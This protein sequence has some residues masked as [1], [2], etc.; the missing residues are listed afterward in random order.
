LS[1]GGGGGFSIK[2]LIVPILNNLNVDTKRKYEPSD[3]LREQNLHG[4]NSA[5]SHFLV[6]SQTPEWTD[7]LERSPILE[8]N[9]HKKTKNKREESPETHGR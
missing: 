4:W 3:D 7:G 1:I 9:A 8:Q 5:G 2:R 6:T